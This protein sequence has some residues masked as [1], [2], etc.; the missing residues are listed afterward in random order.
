MVCDGS[1]IKLVQS[2]DTKDCQLSNKVLV[3]ATSNNP[4]KIIVV[5]QP[6]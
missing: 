3:E 2:H 1:V 6:P 5:Y 4:I